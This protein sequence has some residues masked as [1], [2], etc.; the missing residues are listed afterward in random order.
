MFCNKNF[1]NPNSTAW[2]TTVHK[3]K[4]QMF[5]KIQAKMTKG[6]NETVETSNPVLM[7]CVSHGYE[8]DVEYM[9]D[10][11]HCSAAKKKW[12][13]FEVDSI[14][15]SRSHSASLFRSLEEFCC[16]FINDPR[17]L[18][19]SDGLVQPGKSAGFNSSHGHY[20]AEAISGAAFANSWE[21]RKWCFLYSVPPCVSWKCRNCTVQ[22]MP[23]SLAW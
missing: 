15:K 17:L 1:S 9:W 2:T 22:F 14:F 23:S 21:W 3:R 13:V 10:L 6:L 7:G 16:F 20:R 19:Y 5:T 11:L 8:K 18:F 12:T 4:D